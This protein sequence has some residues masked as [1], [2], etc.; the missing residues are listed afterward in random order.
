MD[1]ITGHMP[2]IITK[3]C[4]VLLC[5]PDLHIPDL[6][7]LFLHPLQEFYTNRNRNYDALAAIMKKNLDLLD[8]AIYDHKEEITDP[9]YCSTLR[10]LMKTFLN[11]FCEC[12]KY[13]ER[14][15]QCILKLHTLLHAIER[16]FKEL[17]F[18][19]GGLLTEAM[20]RDAC[21]T[22]KICESI[23]NINRMFIYNRK[24]L[25][26]ILSSLSLIAP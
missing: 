16:E 19:S 18:A 20:V 11:N 21:Y 1:N 10:F 25:M 23:L 13:H 26:P 7:H 3:I 5:Y 17:M 14:M 9:E 2:T 6:K 24:C 8:H 12:C 4:D 22:C 15:G